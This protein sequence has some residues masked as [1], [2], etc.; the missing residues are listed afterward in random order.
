MGMGAD[1]VEQGK[2]VRKDGKPDGHFLL[3]LQTNRLRRI[4]HVLLRSCDKRGVLTGRVAWDT[5][6]TRLWVLGVFKRNKL[7]SPGKGGTIDRVK[8]RT[9]YSLYASG[10]LGGF[11]PGTNYCAYV[12]FGDGMGV[13]ARSVITEPIRAGLSYIGRDRDRVA[14][15]YDLDQPTLRWGEKHNLAA[16]SPEAR[17]RVRL[18]ARDVREVNGDKADV[19]AAENFS[20]FIFRTRD[21]LRTSQRRRYL[22]A[23]LIIAYWALP[24]SSREKY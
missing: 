15:G 20:Y 23:S 9:R 1:K 7:L 10:P 16:L 18:I 3:S 22:A 11:K 19:V 12:T 21:E 4:V 14:H 6:R 5:D 8:G 17:D 24:T 13:W 2:A